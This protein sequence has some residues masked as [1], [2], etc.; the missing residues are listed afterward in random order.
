[1][2]PPEIKIIPQETE[3]YKYDFK[4]IKGQIQARKASEIAAA[5]MHNMLMMGSPGVGKSIIAKT[6]PSILPDMTLEEQ[7]EI[8]K[9][10]SVAGNLSGSLVKTRPVR[11]PHHTAT[12][13]AMIGGGFNPKPG[14]ITQAHGGIL[15]LDELPEFSRQVIETLR[16]PLEDEK[17]I[18]SRSGGT[19]EFPA[20][21]ILIGAMNPCKCGYYPDMQRCTCTSAAIDRYLRK[22]SRPLLDRIDICVEVPQVRFRDLY[23]TGKSEKSEEI[24]ARVVRTQEIQKMRYRGENFCFNSHIPSSRIFE[25]CKLDK[26]QEIYM[27]QMYDKLNLTARTYHKILRVARTLADMDESEQIKMSHLNEALCYRN[28]DKKFWEGMD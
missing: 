3:D 27:E 22:V 4:N 20:K 26:K 24:R 21:F 16:Q 17:I 14:E 11:S 13:S 2:K 19:Y 9:I 18:V 8:S 7:I 10:Q 5:G 28:I 25:Y 1:M 23:N 12:V 6:M 15:F